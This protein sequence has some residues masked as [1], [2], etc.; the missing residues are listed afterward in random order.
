M[1]I[2]LGILP[3]LTTVQWVGQLY[4]KLGSP[5]P[6]MVGDSVVGCFCFCFLNQDLIAKV[7]T[8]WQGAEVALWSFLPFFLPF[9]SGFEDHTQGLEVTGQVLEL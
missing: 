3:G 5:V 2:F 6:C 1:G 9:F 4:L 8:G 7:H